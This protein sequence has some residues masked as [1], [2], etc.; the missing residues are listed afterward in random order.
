MWSG[1]PISLQILRFVVIHTVK[2]FS[3]VSEAEVDVFLERR[4]G[5]RKCGIE[6]QEST[7]MFSSISP[8]KKP[9]SATVLFCLYR[10]LALASLGGTLLTASAPINP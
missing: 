6:P 1:I 5:I 2:G 7:R 3:M 8:Q 10:S 9:E 4:L